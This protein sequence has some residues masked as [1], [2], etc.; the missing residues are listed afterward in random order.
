[1]ARLNALRLADNLRRRVVEAALADHYLRDEQLRQLCDRHWSAPGSGLLGELWVEGAAS[2]LSSPHSL[3]DLAE[4]GHFAAGLLQQLQ[5]Q[6]PPDRRLYSHQAEA[7]LAAPPHSPLDQQPALF[8]TAGTGAG[9]TESF[10]LPMLNHLWSR[11]RQGGGVRALILY[12]MNALVNDQVHRLE[13]WLAGQ[14]QLSLCRFTSETPESRREAR[15]KQLELGRPHLRL[16][17]RQARGWE[18]DQG[19]ELAPELRRLPPDILITNYSMLEY[20]LARPQDHCFFGEALQVLVLD[21]AHLYTATLAAEITLLLR[22]FLERCGRQ[23][24]HILQIATSATI[25]SGEREFAAQLFSRSSQEV[26]LIRGQR[27]PLE[28]APAAP[29]RGDQPPVL[30]EEAFQVSGL[31]Q[32]REGQEYFLTSD[33]DCR[34]LAHLL[35]PFVSG[36]A[37]QAALEESGGVICHFL[38]AA[39]QRA[40]A[41]QRLAQLLRDQPFVPASQLALQVLG[42]PDLGTLTALLSLLATARRE[43][44]G[45]PLLPHRL[46][47][48]VR[49]PQGLQVCLNSSCSG[50]AADRFGAYGSLVAPGGELCP[51]CQSITLQLLRCRQ[52]GQAALGALVDKGRLRP[53]KQLVL[54]RPTAGGGD[55]YYDLQLDRLGGPG[56]GPSFSRLSSCDICEAALEEFQPLQSL[57]GLYQSVVAETVYAEIPPLVGERHPETLPGQGRRLLAFSDSRSGAARLGP[58]L[59][60]QHETKLVRSLLAR[61]LV[62]GPG[63]EVEPL[64]DQ[65]RQVELALASP[66]LPEVAQRA[67]QASADSLRRQLEGLQSG[68][69]VPQLADQLS[70]YPEVCQIYEPLAAEQHQVESWN[71]R[72]LDYHHQKVVADQAL[73]HR[74]A[75]DLAMP[76]RDTF[77]LLEACGLAEVVYPGLASL[78]P[79]EEL[80]ATLARPC[81]QRLEPLWPHLIAALLDTLRLDRVLTLGDPL[82]DRDHRSGRLPL[83]SWATLAD[84]TGRQARHRRRRFVAQVLE[85]AGAGE[86]QAEEVLA[87]IFQQLF[88][89]GQVSSSLGGYG[90]PQGLAWLEANPAHRA[91][92][93]PEKALRI[94]FAGLQVRRPQQLFL[95]SR[96]GRIF[97]RSLLGCAP[98]QG[99]LGTLEP[100]DPE[101]LTQHPACARVRRDIVES[102]LFRLGLWAEEH[103][104]QLSP[105]EAQRLQELFRAGMRNLLSCTTTME[106]GID[107]G[108]L[109]ATLLANVPPG[110]ANYLQRAGR[111]GRRS[112]GSSV[113]VTFCRS[114]AYDQEVFRRFGDFL[115]RELRKPTVFLHRPRIAQRHL[116]AWLLGT[117]FAQLYS[118]DQ[119]VGAMTAFGRMGGFCGLPQA[120]KTARDQVSRRAEPCPPLSPPEPRPDWWPSD[121]STTVVQ[122][123]QA[124]VA[125][126]RDHPQCFE[127]RLR[128]LFQ[129]TP[130]RPVAATFEQALEALQQVLYGASSGWQESGWVPVYEQLLSAWEQLADAGQANSLFYRLK[131]LY[132]STVIETLGDRQ[133]LPRYGFPIGLQRLRVQEPQESG[134][135]QEDRYRLER[136]GFLALREYVP[137]SRLMVGGKVVTSRGLLKHWTGAALDDAFGIRAEG[138]ECSQGH[139]YYARSGRLGE[140]PVCGSEPRKQHQYLLFPRHGYTTA[141]WDPPSYRL[142]IDYVGE[143]SQVSTAFA[144]GQDDETR[145]DFADLLGL[146][147]RYR[148]AGE[149]VSYNRGRHDR[150]FALCTLCG[151][152]DS[153]KEVGGELAPGQRWKRELAANLK[154]PAGFA[155]HA[156]LHRSQRERPCWGESGAGVMRNQLLAAWETTDV[157]LLEWPEISQNKGLVATLGEA[158]RLAGAE[159]LELDQRELGMLCSA[160]PQGFGSLIFDNV[161]GGAAHVYELFQEGRAWL[162]RAHQVLYRDASHHARCDSACIDCILSYGIQAQVG[163]ALCRREACMWLE[164]ALD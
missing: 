152:A 147:A 153:E 98:H 78:S 136:A 28:L 73:I 82:A 74:L 114:Q 41:Y 145:V 159:M 56:S 102:D 31:G 80:W 118:P 6:I 85:R 4:Q 163:T 137:G 60:M 71:E 81:R 87:A 116:H 49:A 79:P 21:E 124:W 141:A 50:P 11:P 126:V 77:F 93:E 155:Q 54:S 19:R 105:G 32:S 27:A 150:G 132:E 148:A 149:I 97:P 66:G 156:P 75:E 108:G 40:P 121:S 68:T 30:A 24:Q 158:L 100:V 128:P 134:G 33:H 101:Q 20:M 115:G 151:Y 23:P 142:Q 104:A 12:P 112:D 62:E 72:S 154:L 1:M 138:T 94:A 17:R 146:T 25:G 58:Q 144:A 129:G 161:P 86:S 162:Q 26:T 61:S 133:F 53:G 48:L 84:F 8:I 46:H 70:R 92:G 127:G 113:V 107:I 99:C 160:L 96:T 117:F 14:S 64:L 69:S 89:L 122:A 43:L 3:G 143:V 83:G 45:L 111:V 10:L 9:K 119:Q 59:R 44:Q 109:S 55:L 120:A 90:Q 52:C 135:R 34:Q 42:R 35:E 16:T 29:P 125:W 67:L 130:L 57:P 106:L 47:L 95:C 157:V 110:K 5:Q 37:L 164:R 2:S 13:S 91:G 123:F 7:L 63:A 39:L 131:A 65:L 38:Y 36:P 140:C 139:F 18:D 15:R 22:R 103:S 51:H 76:L 88:Q